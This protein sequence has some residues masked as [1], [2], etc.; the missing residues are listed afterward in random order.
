M[1]SVRGVRLHT[2]VY[3]GE[4]TRICDRSSG[5]RATPAPEALQRKLPPVR[6]EVLSDEK[7]RAS[8]EVAQ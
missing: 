3:L 8:M 1:G 5:P 7:L 4:R 2:E 6:W